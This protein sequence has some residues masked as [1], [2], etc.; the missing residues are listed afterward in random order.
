MKWVLK[1][2]PILPPT[3]LGGRTEAQRSKWE[4]GNDVAELHT[5]AILDRRGSIRVQRIFLYLGVWL[6]R[7]ISLAVWCN[8]P[9]HEW[10]DSCSGDNGSENALHIKRGKRSLRRLLHRRNKR[11]RRGIGARHERIIKG[12]RDTLGSYVVV[13]PEPERVHNVLALHKLRE[14]SLCFLC[15]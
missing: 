8:A 12:V 7:T 1:S 10:Q 13:K 11:W 5:A 3:H 2:L 6:I 9:P 15:Q 4:V 14:F